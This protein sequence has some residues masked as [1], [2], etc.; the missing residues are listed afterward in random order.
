[1]NLTNANPTATSPVIHHAGEAP[2]ISSPTATRPVTMAGMYG[3]TAI[4]SP[5][6]EIEIPTISAMPI[7]TRPVIH[8]AGVA[9]PISRPSATKPVIA[10]G[11][12]RA[13]SG[14]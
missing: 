12:K 8:H 1:M 14:A 3:A 9:P 2:A 10:A 4:L 11:M 6:T 5:L 7:A 13:T